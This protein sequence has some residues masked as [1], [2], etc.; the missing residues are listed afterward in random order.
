MKIIITSLFF[1]ISFNI[2]SQFEILGHVIDKI[3][4]SSIP[5]T[6]VS[7]KGVTNKTVTDENGKFKLTCISAHPAIE[8]TFI[9]YK[10]IEIQISSDTVLTLAMELDTSPLEGTISYCYFGPSR[11]FT[12]GYYGG[13]RHNPV[14]FNFSVSQPSLFRVPIYLSG[15]LSYRTDLQDNYFLN[16]SVKRDNQ[17]GAFSFY[18]GM[19]YAK[20]EVF[21]STEEWLFKEVNIFSE[22]LMYNF[23][24]I[25]GAGKQTLQ[26]GDLTQTNVGP[27]LGIRK[28]IAPWRIEAKSIAKYWRNYWQAEVGLVKQIKSRIDLGVK[29]VMIKDY[30]EVE[31][32][33]RYRFYY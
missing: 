5:G 7:E 21:S 16:A 19:D 10:P 20:G 33:A 31:F 27:Q 28:Y 32:L 29:G 2:N 3:D 8:F 9:G 13:A 1:I 24:V 15:D 4:G 6:N 23:Y 22:I 30:K 25:A 26:Q 14:G 18:L 12:L 17:I 11:Y